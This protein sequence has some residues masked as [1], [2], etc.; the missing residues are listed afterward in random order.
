MPVIAPIHGTISNV[1]AQI[2]G[3]VDV[4]AAVAEIVDNSSL[5]LDLNV[6]ERDLAFLKVGQI[7]HFT[8]TNN[9]ASEY[10][11][12]VFSIGAA[13][14]NESKTIPVHARVKG[15]KTGLIDGMNITGI[16]SLD[17]VLTPAV[18]KDAV[19]NADGKYYIF[20]VTDKQIDDHDEPEKDRHATINFEKV[21]VSVGISTMGY[22]AITPIG[23]LPKT[24]KVVITGAFFINARLSNS[25]G[26]DAH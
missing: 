11:A 1:N 10:D 22:T 13:F 7:I 21:E 19:V 15:N 18:A 5:H 12:E 26:H 24:A 4:S 2:G 16:V 6:F 25:G 8:L 20:I 3:Y 17:N 14:E 9:P 23:N